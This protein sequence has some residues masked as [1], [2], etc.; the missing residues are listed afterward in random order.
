M[1]SKVFADKWELKQRKTASNQT[2]NHIAPNA[3]KQLLGNWQWKVLLQWVWKELHPHSWAIKMQISIQDTA[4]C[5]P[6]LNLTTGSVLYELNFVHHP[7][8]TGCSWHIVL[9][10]F[11]YCKEKLAPTF[12]S[13][14]AQRASLCK[15]AVVLFKYFWEDNWEGN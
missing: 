2:Q 11:L 3:S 15:D 12:L 8:R 5:K 14:K 10:G 7:Y 6:L 1:Q 13:L 9:F 4:C